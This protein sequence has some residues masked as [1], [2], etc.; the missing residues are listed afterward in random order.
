MPHL[1]SEGLR[2]AAA[3]FMTPP[4]AGSPL[5]ATHVP[6]A[7]STAMAVPGNPDALAE[8]FAHLAAAI[9]QMPMALISLLD[10]DRF[11]LLSQVGFAWPSHLPRRQTLCAQALWHKGVLAV[12]DA[13]LE[14]SL[15]QHPWV[16][17]APG[18]RAYAAVPLL[19]RPG[20]PLGVLSVLGDSPK[21]L[22]T[23]QKLQL[24]LLADLV[25]QQLDQHAGQRALWQ[26]WQSSQTALQAL[27]EHLPA[28]FCTLDE[29]A[30]VLRASQHWLQ[31][32][33]QPAAKV[34]GQPL[35]QWV[36][37]E[38]RTNLAA[39][40]HQL[41]STGRLPAFPLRL[42]AADGSSTAVS[43]QLLLGAET[44]SPRVYLFAEAAQGLDAYT[45]FEPWAQAL[46]EG[47]VRL[48]AQGSICQ[49]NRQAALWLG[50]SD[51]AT[52]PQRL[53]DIW[54]DAC[55]PLAAGQYTALPS[56]A[57][58][59]PL[60]LSLW[61]NPPPGKGFTALLQH[62]GQPH[63][64]L[65]A[66]E[67][68]NRRVA[69]STQAA[70]IGVWQWDKA[71]N[72]LSWDDTLHRLFHW[73]RTRPLS[74]NLWLEAIHPEDAATVERTV[75]RA[76]AGLDL[77]EC[78]FRVPLASGALRYMQACASVERDAQGQ[79]L[80]LM[81]TCWD[82]TPQRATELQL[83]ESHRFLARTGSLAGVGGWE[84]VLPAGPIIWSEQTCRLH[85]VPEGFSPS[86]EEAIGF[87]APEA[88]PMIQAAVASAI[89]LGQDFD[90]EL[91]LI[92]ARGRQFWARAVGSVEYENGQ[93]VRLVGAFQ[94]ITLRKAI[95]QQL[96][97]HH[98]LL[99]VTLD[100][101]ADAVI[102]TDL[103]GHVRW[104]N[105]VAE[106]LTGWRKDDALGQGIEQ[107]F[108]TLYEQTR[109]PNPS[110]V[111]LCLQQGESLSLYQ[112]LVLL[113][114]DGRELGIQHSASPIRHSD[115]NT[116]GCVLVFNDVSEQRRLSREMSYRAT[117]D[118]LT[119]LVN[120]SEFES[121]LHAGLQLA[122]GRESALMFIDLDQFKVVN[123]TCGHAAGDEL[124]RQISALLQRCMR[125]QDTIARLGGDEFG[126]LLEH[127]TT[128]QAQRVAQK[129][130]DEM[131]HFRF[132]H[133]GR[134]FRLGTS[135]GL[136]PMDGRWDS[137]A[138]LLQTADSACYAAKEAGRN[139]VHLWRPADQ[140]LEARQ[141]QMQWV[142]RIEQAL[143]EDLF[144]L[145]GQ[146]IC[147]IDG[148]QGGLHCEILLRLQN[149]D[150]EWVSP[151]VF[152]PAAERFHMAT[153][154]DRWVVSQ[155]FTWLATQGAQL[156]IELIAVN[157][158]GQSVGDKAFHRFFLTALEEAS[159]NRECLCVEITETAAIT[160]LTEAQV[161]I[162]QLRALGVK[163]ALDDFG[164]G[165][166]SF[167]YLK[168]LPVDFLK[169]DGR[170][171]THLLHDALD[172]AAVRCFQD[173]A[174]VIGVKTV[175]EF[176][177]CPEVLSALKD[178]GIDYAQGFLLH[179]PEPLAN[180]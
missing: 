162:Q 31:H 156:P 24:H 114:K 29:Q 161:F 5:D 57:D 32:A 157:L 81:G 14:P 152:L 110:P 78:E 8:R 120:R 43:V 11:Y 150:G 80:G 147:Q 56:P 148:P 98:Q 118:A 68:L 145:F 134:R 61:Q 73:P 112:P 126:V 143:D 141:G 17:Q 85:E 113:A 86:L 105:P 123:D 15:A 166:S 21:H 130:C 135:I 116:L 89:A 95:E 142:S 153:R 48:D 93:A 59:T 117:H 171:I 87:Y 172:N 63:P 83:R 30:R 159:F 170:F 97:E 39:Q 79:P 146:R 18:V 178:L 94:D 158:S 149:P 33:G 138:A 92:S 46:P 44:P 4:P 2:P 55:P 19:V 106:S 53:Q 119:G 1:Y 160:N 163:V 69:V 154:I 51:T 131:E 25:A 140:S 66:L 111:R 26:Q 174:R 115:G 109:T 124:L 60:Q 62:P 35:W 34:L 3:A 102:T 10:G 176:V 169:I 54:P 100:S 75:L 139:R 7:S 36:A 151:Q 58:G 82:I 133:E 136:V 42:L 175:A 6:A 144:T 47:L 107:V 103:D 41:H 132:F 49:S 27:H 125:T 129:I 137:V 90:V 23:H 128:Q 50:L 64:E 108:A 122:S 65:A 20:E 12:T 52:G 165:A 45:P 13:R 71:S 74:L 177:E 88:R 40:L 84:M 91:P 72:R 9:C 168:T 164:A 101:I 96:E 38:D 28:L 76:L 70:S 179:R 37:A 180:L 22:N 121:R 127:C 173:V 99:Q 77:A 16:T 104:L 167:G 67:A 155:L